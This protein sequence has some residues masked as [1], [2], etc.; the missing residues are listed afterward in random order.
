MQKN[1]RGFAHLLLV[2]LLVVVVGIIGFVGW[3]LAMRERN[4]YSVPGGSGP[5]YSGLAA[6]SSTPPFSTLPTTLADYDQIIPLGNVNVPDHTQPT[7]HLYSA[8]KHLGGTNGT[9]TNP[10]LLSPGKVVVTNITNSGEKKDG[11]QIS[12]DYAI[13]F[14]PCK[15]MSFL[16]GHVQTLSG[17]VADAVKGGSW[18]GPC[19]RRTPAAGEE[20]FYCSK[21][22]DLLLEPGELIGKVGGK[23]TIGAFDF[24]A[25]KEGYK[26]PGFVDSNFSP[27]VNAVCPL[28]YFDS[29]T[30]TK[31]YTLV[32]RTTEPRCG[33][34]GQDKANT[35]Q[36]GWYGTN[37]KQRALQDWNG[38]L[39]LVHNNI[40][41][42]IGLLGVGGKISQPA[43]VAFKPRH[44]GTTN[45]EPSETTAGTVYCYQDEGLLENNSNPAS[46]TYLIELVDNNTLKVAY[47]ASSCGTSANLSNPTLFY[48]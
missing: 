16:F 17:K 23:P 5:N 44:S 1:K 30:Q 28:D 36:G 11:V 47:Q 21:N 31:L 40:D 34:I 9:V 45:R 2:L 26:D 33:T 12:N 18:D 6:C 7:D 32:K 48:R 13:T 20:T 10:E 42:S 8:F 43:K 24:G 38:Q 14:T 19:D 35:A 15:G 4:R 22:T 3:Y 41:P 29:A 39:A 37:D 46:G 25:R 27:T